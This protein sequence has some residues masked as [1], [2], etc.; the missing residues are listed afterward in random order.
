MRRGI[1]WG[2][3]EGGCEKRKEEAVEGGMASSAEQEEE[4]ALKR[5]QGVQIK[6]NG[7]S[8]AALPAQAAKAH[9]LQATLA[10]HA[11]D[12]SS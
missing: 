3:G 4:E 8:L 1:A 12:S 9:R 5:V 11:G 10:R 2:G 7:I 6:A